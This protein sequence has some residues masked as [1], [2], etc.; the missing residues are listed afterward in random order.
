MYANVSK[1]TIDAIAF[2]L[3]LLVLPLASFGMTTNYDVLWWIGIGLVLVGGLVPLIT[4][5]A[6]AWGIWFVDEDGG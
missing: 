6:Q 3:L 2:A 1:L 4:T 5:R